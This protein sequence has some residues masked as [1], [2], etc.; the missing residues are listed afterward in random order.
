MVEKDAL[1]ELENLG[2]IQKIIDVDLSEIF[3]G[4]FQK[5]DGFD[6]SL[7]LIFGGA[8]VGFVSILIFVGL[9]EMNFISKDQGIFVFLLSEFIFVNF[10]LYMKRR[11]NKKADKCSKYL[12]EEVQKKYFLEDVENI[13]QYN[14]KIKSLKENTLN[15]LSYNEE[16]VKTCLSELKKENPKFI[17][18]K[19]IILKIAKPMTE[20]ALKEKDYKEVLEKMHKVLV[21]DSDVIN[22]KEKSD[23]FKIVEID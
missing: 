18:N 1:S 23:N 14:Q 11:A 15:S 4:D 22:I 3:S 7:S 16:F 17:N 19:N 6:V 13:W 8:F 10:V 21:E 12:L 9:L 5:I 2:K 20:Q